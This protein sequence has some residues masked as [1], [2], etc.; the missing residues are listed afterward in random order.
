MEAK[1]VNYTHSDHSM[2]IDLIAKA[3]GVSEAENYM[4]SLSPNDKNNKLTHGAL[5][6]AYCTKSMEEKALRLFD[7]MTEKR[8]VTNALPFANLMSMYMKMGK[9]EKV[10]SLAAEMKQRNI[11]MSTYTYNLAMQ[12]HAAMN[13]IQGVE[14][15]LRQIELA[16]SGMLD[17]TTYSNLATIYVKAGLFEKAK[18]ALGKVE[19]MMRPGTRESF[20]FLMSLYAGIGRAEDVYR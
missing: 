19:R 5:L 11:F 14:R 18:E 7:E 13:D 1:K 20:H 12:S 3:K 10:L 6:N 4:N 17:W 15:V 2:R 16:D 8:L 9:H